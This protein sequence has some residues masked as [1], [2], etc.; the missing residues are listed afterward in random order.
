MVGGH[1][2][3]CDAC[4]KQA[5]SAI[6]TGPYRSTEGHI[7]STSSL[8]EPKDGRWRLLSLEPLVMSQEGGDESRERCSAQ[9]AVVKRGRVGF[10]CEGA[11]GVTKAMARER[12]LY[13]G[14]PDS[15]RSTLE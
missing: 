11:E 15:R 6:F 3:L 8:M 13:K 10:W 5:G 4:T 7:P 1:E 12:A 2:R 14:P 9:G